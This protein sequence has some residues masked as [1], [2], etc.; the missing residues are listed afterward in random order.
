MYD[1]FK[2]FTAFFINILPKNMK[3]SKKPY[4][5]FSVSLK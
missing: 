5:K 2:K 4:E 1:G 3:Q